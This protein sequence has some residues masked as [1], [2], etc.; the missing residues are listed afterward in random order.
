MHTVKEKNNVHIRGKAD[1]AQTII[2]GHGFGSD[3]TAFE[4]LVKAFEADYK[5]VLFDNVGGGKADINAFSPSRYS[6]IQGY[7][8][9]LGD[10]LRELQLS[11]IIYVGH[12]VNGMIGLLSAIKYPSYF[13]KLVLLGSSPRYLNEPESGYIGGFNMEALEQLYHAMSTNYYAWASGFA[14]LVVQNHD[15]PEL[16]ASFAKSLSSIRA[17]IALSVAKAIF[18][19][20]HRSDLG[21]S[22]IPAMIVQTTEDPAVPKVVGAY[23]HQHILNSQL[24]TVDTEGH[25]PHVSAPEEVI[26]IIKSFI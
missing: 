8:T 24:A 22:S 10:L 26:S 21:K 13:N 18:E 15:R 23:M 16:A 6:S 14:Q 1:A 20:D 4:P 11:D 3:Q 2:F 19:M 12:S 7:V 5:I 9:D 25:F 17:D